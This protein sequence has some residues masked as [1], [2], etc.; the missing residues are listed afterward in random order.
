MWVQ[1]NEVG[2]GGGGSRGM[3][4]GGGGVRRRHWL[5]NERHIFSK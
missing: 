4:L 2:R 5:Q 3:K 1:R